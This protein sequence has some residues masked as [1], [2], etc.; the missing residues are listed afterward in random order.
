M[1][2]RDRTFTNQSC[3]VEVQ[4]PVRGKHKLEKYQ[5][6]YEDVNAFIAAQA[7]KK[8]DEQTIASGST[9]IEIFTLFDIDGY[10]RTSSRLRKDEQAAKRT[11]QRAAKDKRGP[12]KE[13]RRRRKENAESRPSTGEELNHFKKVFKHVVR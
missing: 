12:K 5:S 3:R 7:R 8:P 1:C 11:E 9:W 4:K 13:R 10:R 2:I 6:M